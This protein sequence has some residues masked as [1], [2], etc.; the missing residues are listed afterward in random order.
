MDILTRLIAGSGT[1]PTKQRTNTPAERLSTC[2]SICNTLT[3]IW[4]GGAVEREEDA[5]LSYTT[6]LLQRLENILHDE[7]RRA[8]PHSCLRCVAS[9]QTYIIITKL[10][11]S[12]RNTEIIAVSAQLFH[13]LINGEADGLLDSKLFT[14]S[15]LDLVCYATIGGQVI[16]EERLETDLVEL[17][18][19]IATKIRLDPD[20]L[21]A[22]F[23]PDRETARGR[24]G[25]D[26]TRR[27]QFPLFFVLVQYVHHDGSVG[28]FA[29]TALLYLTET[30]SKFKP[31]ETWMIESD[32][33]PQM[34]SGLGA[35]YSRLGRQSTALTRDSS[36]LPIV[37][38]SDSAQSLETLAEAPRHGQQD[39]KAFF[40]YLAFWQDTLN[41]CKSLEVSDT[42]LDHFQVLF[43]QQLLYPSLLES[44]DV[45]GGS[46]AAVITHLSRMLRAIEHFQLVDRILRYL[47]AS[48]GAPQIP[49]EKNHRRQR[50][51][52]SRSKSIDQLKTLANMTDSPC[53]NLFNLL[54]LLVLSLKSSHAETVNA[55]L[56]L[57]SVIVERHHCHVVTNLF[58]VEPV[59]ARQRQKGVDELNGYLCKLFD[60]SEAVATD[61][62]LDGSYQAALSDGQVMLEQHSCLVCG[63]TDDQL[64]DG[65]VVTITRGCKLFEAVA[66]LLQNFFANDSVTNL[67]L[68]EALIALTACEHMDLQG[69][70]LPQGDGQVD[71]NSTYNITFIISELTE[72]VRCWRSQ[73][74][75]WDVLV[76]GRRLELSEEDTP[77]FPSKQPNNHATGLRSQSPS[78]ALS[79]PQSRPAT[80]KGR[81]VT[82]TEFGSINN[83]IAKPEGYRANLAERTLGQSPLHQSSQADQDAGTAE[84]NTTTSSQAADMDSILRTQV[85]VSNARTPKEASE[86][87]P[88]HAGRKQGS[89]LELS[90]I[91]SGLE[92]SGN[93]GTSTPSS[94]DDTGLRSRASLSHVLT[95]AVILQEFILEM[96]A[97]VQLRATFFDEVGLKAKALEV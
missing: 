61:A 28:D 13:I 54:D 38:L 65:R 1:S 78:N 57:L 94:R 26:E 47:L 24:Q 53:P 89:S 35:L 73:F 32:L 55:C 64:L 48:P 40:S 10:A 71:D 95:N 6:R 62:D 12:S 50:M 75:G 83:A 77:V 39:V 33:A 43:V 87:L 93:S 45:E 82:T 20:I 85:N 79:I 86:S 81:R 91:P 60:Y 58:K 11:V 29:R 30:A 96:A 68:T 21:P 31:L 67:Y 18:F 90:A 84:D 42:L 16:V 9:S 25:I 92:E 14:R 66:M 22:W 37:A 41:H 44:S 19:E 69:W 8:A 49:K 23:H 80:P 3:Q 27:S 76:S 56:K 4:R 46:T 74:P 15:L 63:H 5:A 36:T 7:S 17:L 72:Q 34:A 2:K 51:S 70:L 88:V 97:I 52:M 59:D